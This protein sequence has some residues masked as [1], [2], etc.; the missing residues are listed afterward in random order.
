MPRS[1]TTS[2]PCVSGSSRRSYNGSEA[3]CLALASRCD[4]TTAFLWRFCSRK[5]RHG[6]A[7]RIAK[8]LAAYTCVI[9]GAYFCEPSVSFNSSFQWAAGNAISSAFTQ[10]SSD[11][12]QASFGYPRAVAVSLTACRKDEKSTKLYSISGDWE[13]QN[14]RYRT[15]FLGGVRG[16]LERILLPKK[17]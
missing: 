1:C 17:V 11:F 7:V 3:S 9:T 13:V 5:L 12:L 10:N 2:A 6:T 4:V 8:T 14:T 15:W 16:G